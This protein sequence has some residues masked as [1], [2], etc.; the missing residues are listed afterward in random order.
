M[1]HF[2][3]LAKNASFFLFRRL[4]CCLDL[5]EL[6][7]EEATG[8]TD[9][10]AEPLFDTRAA[11]L[12][13]NARVAPFGSSFGWEPTWR[14]KIDFGEERRFDLVVMRSEEVEM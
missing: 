9:E 11:L 12:W 6:A 13:E 3:G 2:D 10:D 14:V 8:L 7:E 1:V 4:L 5:T